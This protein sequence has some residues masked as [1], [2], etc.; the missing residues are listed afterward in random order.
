MCSTLW[1]SAVNVSLSWLRLGL[2]LSAEDNLE[3]R[4]SSSQGVLNRKFRG[5]SLFHL[6]SV[7]TNVSYA[8]A[9]ICKHESMKDTG[10][11]RSKRNEGKRCIPW[12]NFGSRD[13]P[14]LPYRQSRK[15]SPL[16]S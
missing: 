3:G 8:I 11:S 1:Y 12:A 16:Q 13:T 10:I 7:A 9:V 14:P 6:S 5:R 15:T 4:A 2:L